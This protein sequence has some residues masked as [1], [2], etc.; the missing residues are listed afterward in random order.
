MLNREQ[1]MEILPHR[2]SMLLIDRVLEIEPG[3]RCVAETE[4][5]GDEWFFDGHFPGQPVMPGVIIMECLA[6]AGAV[7]ILSLP[8]FKGKIGLFAGIDKARFKLQVHPGDTLR[9]EVEVVKLRG[10]VGVGK[11]CAYLDGK[12][13]AYGEL[14]FAIQ[15]DQ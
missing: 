15:S 6:Q 13:A 3:V 4:L 5:V 2:A 1:I 12:R 14:M 11:A 10:A 7:A 8:E 9:L